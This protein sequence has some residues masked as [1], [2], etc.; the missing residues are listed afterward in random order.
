MRAGVR[1][2]CLQKGMTRGYYT[3]NPGHCR[4]PFPA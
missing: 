1:K 3:G 4:G 2:E